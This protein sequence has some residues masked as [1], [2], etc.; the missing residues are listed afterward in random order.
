MIHV[1]ASIQVK[2]KVEVKPLKNLDVTTTSVIFMRRVFKEKLTR[3]Q[4]GHSSEASKMGT[5]RNGGAI[6]I[7]RSEQKACARK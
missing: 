1:L 5:I 4:E 3:R 7:H 6:I 2:M